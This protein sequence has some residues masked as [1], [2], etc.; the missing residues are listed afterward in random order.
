M[1]GLAK[2]NEVFTAISFGCCFKQPER[3]NVVDRQAFADLFPAI[4]AASVL[5]RDDLFSRG[6]PSPTPI[7]S[8]AT[9]PVSSKR[10]FWLR[11]ITALDAAEI[12]GAV[13]PNQPRLLPKFQT[14]FLTGSLYALLPFWACRSANLFRR[15]GVCWAHSFSKLVSDQVMFGTGVQK[16]RCLPTTT[17]RRRAKARFVFPVWLHLESVAA[18][19]AMFFNHTST[20]AM[21]RNIGNRTTLVAC[22]RVEEAY[23]QPD[24]FVA[25][26][27]PP[28]Q[29][30]FD[31]E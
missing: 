5:F 29:T 20:I 21:R 16:G 26:P 2:P 4:V 10:A 19:F 9:Y 23:R 24:L 14:A 25:P 12:R 1:A 28:E 6:K 27:T 11:G 13:L 18:C 22:K 31:L 15:K 7:C 30:G 17:A 3:L 8:R